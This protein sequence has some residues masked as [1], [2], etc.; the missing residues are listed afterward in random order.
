VWAAGFLLWGATLFL[1]APYDLQISMAVV[2]RTSVFGELVSFWGEWPA[3]AVI[4]LSLATLIAGRW[5]SARQQERFGPW[6][7]LAG[8]IIILAL[9][10]PTLITQC[11]KFFWG[12]V[13]YMHLAADLSDYT[14]FYVPAGV[15]AG[16]SFP[17]GH[18]AMAFISVAIPFFLTAQRRSRWVKA[19]CWVLALLYGCGVAWGRVIHGKHFLTDTLFAAGST[20][21]LAPVILRWL[22][23]QD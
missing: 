13:R 2:D 21:L 20:A 12:R 23:R 19:L 1:C 3:W 10:S 5:G 6:A 17:S 16:E 15:E 8:T 18:V 22:R 4:I 7:P 14:P 9:L 11:L